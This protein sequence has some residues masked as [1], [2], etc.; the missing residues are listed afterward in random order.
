VAAQRN[1]ARPARQDELTPTSRS[2]ARAGLADGH[3]RR[4]RAQQPRSA[5]GRDS[6]RPILTGKIALAHMKEFPAYNE[7]LEQM[8]SEA[9]REWAEKSR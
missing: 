4:V 9:E 6:R 3:G 2:E 8:E 5:D 7:R 1:G